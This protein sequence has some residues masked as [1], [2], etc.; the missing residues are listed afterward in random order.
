MPQIAIRF[1]YAHFCSLLEEGILFSIAR[2]GDGE[3]KA[4]F[5]ASGHNCDKH[6]Y[7]PK[8]QKELIESLEPPKGAAFHFY[9]LQPLAVRRFG[10]RIEQWLAS[11]HKQDLI[12]VDAD[13]FHRAGSEG[14][15][16]RFINAL[17]ERPVILAGPPHLLEM[18]LFDYDYVY[19]PPYRCHDASN[20]IEREIV[21]R[22]DKA[23]A[24]TVVSISASMAANGITHRLANAYG[25]K[26]TILDIGSL[27]D[28]YAGVVSR[29]YHPLVMERL[30]LACKEACA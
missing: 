3:W 22:L 2:Y 6:P 20:Q 26:H 11:H 5:G 16:G 18:K 13:V 12:W 25:A 14:I 9:G 8:L 1:D 29:K 24:P 17:K 10:A 19:V 7:T 4:I 27:W 30:R 28:P 21:A 23:K 15:L